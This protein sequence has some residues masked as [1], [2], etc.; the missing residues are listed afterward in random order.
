MGV[1][2]D[3]RTPTGETPFRLTYGADAVISVEI[4]L[5]NYRM[6]NYIEDKNK[7]AMRL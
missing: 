5:T 2:D 3:S 6:Q 1:S 7:E 4:G